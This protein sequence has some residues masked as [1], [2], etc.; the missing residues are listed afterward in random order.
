MNNDLARKN[1]EVE[2]L[3][4]RHENLLKELQLVKISQRD[5]KDFQRE[6][7]DRNKNIF[8]DVN[9]LN[10]KKFEKDNV[11][12]SEVEVVFENNLN[13]RSTDCNCNC[14]IY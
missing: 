14:L 10:N 13:S 6:P 9:K 4:E 8:F 7:I 2:F 1:K 11:S 3:N 5:K 12:R